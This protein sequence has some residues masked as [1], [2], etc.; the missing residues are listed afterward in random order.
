ME[1]EEGEEEVD[2]YAMIEQ[3]KSIGKQYVCVGNKF[4][5]LSGRV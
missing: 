4:I 3:A 5:R 1:E 2:V